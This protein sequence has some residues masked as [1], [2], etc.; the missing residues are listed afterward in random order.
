ML[1]PIVQKSW[2]DFLTEKITFEEREDLQKHERT[3]RPLGSLKFIERLE[4]MLNLK[5]K[6]EKPG[7]KTKNKIRIGLPELNK[8]SPE[9]G[10]RIKK[11]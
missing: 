2:S 7:K 6:P 9:F 10:V 5:L 3:G 11:Q 4:K 1:I 8:V